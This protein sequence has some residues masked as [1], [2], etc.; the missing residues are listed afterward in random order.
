MSKNIIFSK[1]NK[2]KRRDNP[3]N[4]IQCIRFGE[5]SRLRF[6]L[7]NL[8]FTQTHALQQDHNNYNTSNHII[9]HCFYT[10][11]IALKNTI[12]VQKLFAIKQSENP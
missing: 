11:T 4:P 6:I 1:S 2:I 10:L 3:L 5:K 7:F 12:N 9:S 8:L